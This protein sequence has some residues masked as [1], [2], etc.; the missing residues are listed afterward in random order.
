M[1]FNSFSHIKEWKEDKYRK[2]PSY[3][4]FL[5]EGWKINQ[6]NLWLGLI[7][8]A[9]QNISSKYFLYTLYLKLTSTKL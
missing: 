5:L 8:L 9:K 4:V 3:Q 2:I 6:K 1:L 7:E